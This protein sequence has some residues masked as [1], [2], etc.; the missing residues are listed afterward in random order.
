MR[1]FDQT[2]QQS[3]RQL[4]LEVDGTPLHGGASAGYTVQAVLDSFDDAERKRL[5]R[6]RDAIGPAVGIVDS[7]FDDTPMLLGQLGFTPCRIAGE[8]LGGSERKLVVISCP[9]RHTRLDHEDTR[10]FLDR[11]G[12]LI[13]SDRAI[14]LPGISTYLK[15]LSGRGPAR[16]R[17]LMEAGTDYPAQPPVWLDPGHL[18][19]DPTS[20]STRMSSVLASNALTGEPL[21]VHVHAAGGGIVH[22]VG[23]WLQIPDESA[24]TSVERRPLRDVPHFR[25]AGNSY[26]G[27]SLGGFLAQRSM[28]E[29]LIQ[30]IEAVLEPEGPVEQSRM[31]RGK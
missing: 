24:L 8:D 18:P 19:I 5:A 28:V 16:A 15:H 17:L 25:H 14:R 10:R 31:E 4:V 11:G 29:L 22:S 26:P 21:V 7:H 23:H 13:S 20:L 3:S 1:D 30:G 27:I 6:L 2:E 12:I 9:H